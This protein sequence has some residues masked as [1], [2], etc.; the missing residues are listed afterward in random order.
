VCEDAD[1]TRDR[2]TDPLKAL[3]RVA[4][5]L[6]SSRTERT[7]LRRALDA[8][9]IAGIE[10][11]AITEGHT[12][13]AA[14]P[15]GFVPAPDPHDRFVTSL[16]RGH[17][18]AT[19]PD[20]RTEPLPTYLETL[21]NLISQ[22]MAAQERVDRTRH[23]FRSLFGSFPAAVAMQ[24]HGLVNVANNAWN[25]LTGGVT[26][27]QSV[28]GWI[29][30]EDRD[31]AARAI[32]RVLPEPVEVRLAYDPTRWVELEATTQMAFD[33]QQV[34][35]V[36][37]REITDQRSSQARRAIHDRL[38]TMRF[39]TA[40]TAHALENPLTAL[41]ANLDL[42]RRRVAPSREPG[43]AELAAELADAAEAAERLQHLVHDLRSLGQPPGG[44]PGHVDVRRVVDLAVGLTRSHLG[45]RCHV[46][47]HYDDVPPVVGRA[48]GLGQVMVALLHNAAEAF[49]RRD[50]QSGIPVEERPSHTLEIWIRSRTSEVLIEVGDDGPGVPD[51]LRTGLFEPFVGHGTGLGLTLA[52]EIV[53]SLGGSLSWDDR[54]GQG[55]LFRVRL[56]VAQLPR[57]TPTPEVGRRSA[58]GCWWWTTSP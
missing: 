5:V 48:D 33:G 11:L 30:E 24:R 36:V 44:A 6:R 56:P 35:L 7:T 18:E 21:A 31:R 9:R 47:R 29:L 22:A 26:V 51:E 23:E 50:A 39:V 1:M 49:A 46:E 57:T 20:L 37:A 58:A 45:H 52:R 55:S 43:S 15:E 53:E 13:I 34:G 17:L 42:A 14:A 8:A 38:E 41:T 12:P 28:V 3:A 32:E 40:G 54:S 10:G 19:G 25:V 16:H 4:S 27:G 2:Q